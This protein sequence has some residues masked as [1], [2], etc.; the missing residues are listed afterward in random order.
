MCM[1]TMMMIIMIMIMMNM[2]MMMI[3]MI[4]MVIAH[5]LP[6]HHLFVKLSQARLLT[7]LVNQT[8]HTIYLFVTYQDFSM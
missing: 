7:M 5:C 3:T 8:E 6:F 4:M 2:I 1:V